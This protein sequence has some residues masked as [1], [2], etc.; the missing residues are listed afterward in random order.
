V[1]SLLTEVGGESYA[2][3][4]TSIVR[5]L[6]VAAGEI[7]L[8]EGRQHFDLDG[9][10]VGLIAAH[11]VLALDARPVAGA[12]LPVVVIG[13]TT[14]AYGLIVD[15]LVGQRELVVQP[16]DPQLGKVKD[17]AAGALMQDGSPVLI[18]DVE[19]VL[20]SIDKIVSDNR[21]ASVD[22]YVTAEQR[23]RKRVLVVEDSFTVRELE[24]K[25]LGGRGYDVEVAVD[26]MDGWNAVRTGQ[27]DLVVSDIDMPRMDGIELVT[28]I[29][30]DALLK[31]LPVI[32]VSYKDRAEDRRRGLEAGAAYYL[33]K[34]SFHDETLVQAVVDLIGE[35][36]V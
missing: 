7:E 25:L 34:S 15:R 11:Q 17:I 4:L 35:P 33:T 5:A 31:S 28:L 12:E 8:V 22:P 30:K 26:G 3:P 14:H 6:K 2:F 21:L 1:R 16:L 32:V 27:F 24:R 10:S 19:D 9:R 29:G 20:R 18:V 23:R 36:D 13:D